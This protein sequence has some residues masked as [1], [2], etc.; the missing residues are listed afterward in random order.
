MANFP[1]TEAGFAAAMNDVYSFTALHPNRP[2]FLYVPP[3]G[4]QY[5]TSI[6]NP[7]DQITEGT[8][9]GEYNGDSFTAEDREAREIE[10]RYREMQDN[11]D[12]VDA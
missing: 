10:R 4:D 1:R 7:G 8:A 6:I 11:P 3:S 2:L 5:I 9:V 12:L